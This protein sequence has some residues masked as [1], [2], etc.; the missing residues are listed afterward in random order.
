MLTPRSRQIPRWFAYKR[1]PNFLASPSIPV[2]IVVD[3]DGGAYVLGDLLA[4]LGRHPGDVLEVTLDGERL[5]VA[6]SKPSP[7]EP[8][9]A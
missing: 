3:M 1:A 8:I 5:V 7:A 6:A 4:M 2:Q 9:V